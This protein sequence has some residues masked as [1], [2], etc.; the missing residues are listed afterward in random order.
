MPSRLM[1]SGERQAGD[2][3][4]GFDDNGM[5]CKA[6]EI[7]NICPWDND[8]EDFKF[9][10]D[11][12]G[13]GPRIYTL[14]QE[15]TWTRL[16]PKSEFGYWVKLIKNGENLALYNKSWFIYDVGDPTSASSIDILIRRVTLV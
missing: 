4:G 6:D 15:L 14:N 8:L 7:T 2:M 3:I 16:W 9:S 1:T 12:L 11:I 5:L 13:E 10:V